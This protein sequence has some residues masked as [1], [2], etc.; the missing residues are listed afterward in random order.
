MMN[1]EDFF[2]F[3]REREWVRIRKENGN[4]KPWTRLPALQ[5]SSFCNIFREDDKT[6][7][8]FKRNLR[9]PAVSTH[10]LDLQLLVCV[11]FRWFNSIAAGEIIKGSL[12]AGWNPELVQALLSAEQ[13]A[14]RAVF[15]SG[16]YINVTGAIGVK[17]KT[18]NP[19]IAF[20]VARV[21]E[22]MEDAD[23]VIGQDTLEGARDALAKHRNLGNF[24]AYE[25]VTDLRHTDL[26]SSAPDINTWASAGPGSA[27]G[28][29]WVFHDDRTHFKYT[30][31]ADAIAMLDGMRE[32]LAVSRSPAFWPWVERPW[33]MRE[34]EHTLCE[35]DKYRRVNL[36]ERAKRS[37]NG[38]Q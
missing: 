30:R 3:A 17:S 10:D 21:T 12:L 36:G 37:Y 34:V 9:D 19:G 16:Y 26:L 33:E 8:W 27:A 23:S 15:G 35:Y 38:L 5:T 13:D 22:L 20:A 31:K 2:F 11:A 18:P 29:G 14:G 1:I 32:I 28:L 4:P 6:T 24:M 7:R 25:I